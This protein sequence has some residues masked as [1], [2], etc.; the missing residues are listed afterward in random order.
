RYLKH[1]RGYSL[2]NAAGLTVG[3]TVSLVLLLYV[4]D[5]A[6]YN[7]STQ[8]NGNVYQAVYEVSLNRQTYLFGQ[9]S[10]DLS[11]F[12]DTDK[13][14][15]LRFS[16][17]KGRDEVTTLTA[18]QPLQHFFALT[19]TEGKP[20]TVWSQPGSIIVSEA[21]ARKV[22]GSGPYTGRRLSAG[23]R[24]YTIAAVAETIPANTVIFFDILASP[25]S[26]PQQNAYFYT[27]LKYPTRSQPKPG[28]AF[29]KPLSD[30]FAW[31]DKMGFTSSVHLL[32]FEQMYG[33]KKIIG[34]PESI[35]QGLPLHFVLIVAFMV[36]VLVM[37]NY[38]AMATVQNHCRLRETGI[39]K[40]L[41]ASQSQVTGQF[42]AESFLLIVLAVFAGLILT[43]YLLPYFN[44]LTGKALTLRGEWVA[45]EWGAILLVTV[46]AFIGAIIIPSVQLTGTRAVQAAGRVSGNIPCYKNLRIWWTASQVGILWLLIFLALISLREQGST[47]VSSRYASTASFSSQEG[48]FP[49]HSKDSPPVHS[50]LETPSAIPGL[51]LKYDGQKVWADENKDGQYALRT[52]ISGVLMSMAAAWAIICVWGLLGLNVFDRQ[53]HS[54]SLLFRQMLGAT[55]HE[56]VLLAGKR[57]IYMTS[58]AILIMLPLAYAAIQ[59]WLMAVYFDTT[60]SHRQPGVPWWIWVLSVGGCLFLTIIVSLLPFYPGKRNRLDGLNK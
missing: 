39:R 57:Y 47:A 18:E 11:P 55:R 59:Y 56:L 30:S 45:Y 28:S 52:N 24:S 43:E 4:L 27:F 38:T 41:G 19:F 49:T 29:R 6:F 14:S 36:L 23:G 17:D 51:K 50:A 44:S 21:Y 33:R 15:V 37:G 53:H 31:L 7:R 10:L 13:A 58:M 40:I 60:A 26:G 34:N 32:P 1:H 12:L 2:V 54:F 5:D 46:T 3:I 16:V 8:T 48:I 42:V 35:W 25:L 22:L 9:T 20:E